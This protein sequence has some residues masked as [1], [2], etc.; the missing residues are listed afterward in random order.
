MMDPKL[1][2][3]RS[4]SVLP[5]QEGTGQVSSSSLPLVGEFD[6]ELN[7]QKQLGAEVLQKM[8]EA[9][10]SEI[11]AGVAALQQLPL[12]KLLSQT[13]QQVAQQTLQQNLSQLNQP[14][15]KLPMAQPLP[16]EF[17]GISPYAALLGSPLQLNE[18]DAQIL[19]RAIQSKN[20]PQQL[21]NDPTALHMGAE[22][23]MAFDAGPVGF[24]TRTKS[25]P[26]MLSSQDFM[27]AKAAQQTGAKLAPQGAAAWNSGQTESLTAL[28]AWDLNPL[29][30]SPKLSQPQISMNQ[31]DPA[32]KALAAQRGLSQVLETQNGKSSSSR[33]DDALKNQ[34]GN[35]SFG[36]GVMNVAPHSDA[37][38]AMDAPVT[39]GGAAKP[40]LS[41]D[42]LVTLGT[43]IK[44]LEGQGGG[45]IHMRLKPQNLGE[46]YIRVS[47]MGDQV[48]LKIRASDGNAKK[49]IEESISGLRDKL[50]S[51][52]LTLA[53]FDVSTVPSNAGTQSLHQQGMSMDFNQQSQ[54]FQRGQEAYDQGRQNMQDRNQWG[55]KQEASRQPQPWMAQASQGRTAQGGL[56]VFA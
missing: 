53:M 48:S 6:K 19:A 33:D 1:L 7:A 40:V 25:S 16:K 41:N 49:I 11:G 42:A 5:S 18:K 35:A 50:S 2:A 51:Q 46:V 26:Q 27:E 43:Q 34:L 30:K 32:L 8:Q 56:N 45:E 47:T 9:E 20:S 22:D 29:S 13:Q 23:E 24:Q 12:Q 37:K 52:N 28:N 4:N 14:G 10:A 39:L 54:S 3:L 55:V 21:A 36:M 15:S 38:M 31:A 44:T 17:E